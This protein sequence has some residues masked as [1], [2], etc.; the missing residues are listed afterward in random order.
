MDKMSLTRFREIKEKMAILPKLASGEISED[1]VTEEMAEEYDAL[2]DELHNSD[3]SDIPVSEYEGFFDPGVDFEGTGA[4][5]DFSII[6]E[7]YRDS[8]P[9]RVKGCNISNFDFDRIPY[10]ED[11]FEEEF[12]MA[13]R[14]RFWGLDGQDIPKEVR[15]RYNNGRLT[16]SDIITYDLEDIPE[17]KIDYQARK[18]LK[19][20][21]RD[22]LKQA[23]LELIDV[24]SYHLD[25][26]INSNGIATLDEYNS[27]LKECLI[28]LLDGYTREELYDRLSSNSTVRELIPEYIIDFPEDKQELKESF[29]DNSIHMND[30]RA[31]LELFRGKKFVNRL[32]NYSYRTRDLDITEEKIMYLF[33]NYP[34]YADE[35]LGH[36]GYFTEIASVIDI[37]KSIE[38]NT[39]SIKDQAK[40]LANNQYLADEAEALRS[41][42]TIT[43]HIEDLGEWDR[44]RYDKILQYTTPE[45]IES[46]DIPTS[47][48][49][50]SEVISVF[51]QFGF[52]RVMEFDRENDHVFSKNDYAFLKTMYEYYLHYGGNDH[53]PRTNI[54][55]IQYAE[56]E[57]DYQRPYTKEEFEDM[58]A[59]VI[60]K[61]HLK[62]PEIDY[63]N[64]SDS[65][66]QRHSEMFLPEEATQDLKDK[67]YSRTL[68]VTD[69][70]D[71]EDWIEYLKETDYTYG[72][73][74]SG[75]YMN[76][77]EYG[78]YNYASLIDYLSNNVDKE[79]GLRFLQENGEYIRFI[80]GYIQLNDR[81][82]TDI[83]RIELGYDFSADEVKEQLEKNIVDEVFKNA[84]NNYTYEQ[85]LMY[86]QELVKYDPKITNAMRFGVSELTLENPT[87]EDF[88][89]YI[90][91]KIVAGMTLGVIKYGPDDM[92]NE[93]KEK[94]PEFFISDDA[95]EILK[96]KFYTGYQ[97]V[98]PSI[99]E[100]ERISVKNKFGISDLTNPEFI[101]F[102]ETKKIPN[103]SRELVLLQ[104][105]FS[106]NQLIR[107]VSIDSEAFLLYAQN[108]ETVAKLRNAF[109][110]YPSNFAREEV[111]SR[112]K[113]SELEF[114]DRIKT[115]SEF[116][117]AYQ[118]AILEYEK[119]IVSMPG[120]VLC[121]PEELTRTDL[122]NYRNLLDNNDLKNSPDFRRDVY[123]QI[124]GNMYGLM[125]FDESKRL[126]ESPELSPESLDEVYQIDGRI[127]DLYEKKFELTG[128]IKTLTT[129]LNGMPSLLPG[130]E[131]VSSRN[132]LNLFKTI[133]QKISEGY[134]G[135][136]Q[137]LLANALQ[138]N[139]FEVNSQAMQ[140]LTG[141]VISMH[142]EMKLENL[143]EFTSTVIESRIQENAKT[144]KRIKEIY[145][146][147]LKYS[148]NKSE[149]V[150]STLVREYLENEFKRVKENGMP[151]YSP[152]V[153]KHL[154]DLV[155]FSK[156]LSQNPEIDAIANKTIV[157]SLNE[158]SK[159]IGKGWIRKV[160][161]AAN[162][163]NKMT[164]EQA[165][166]LD[167]S[168]YGEDSPYETE[169]KETVGLKVLTDEERQSIYEILKQANY[170]K[171]LTFNKAEMMFSGIVAPFSEEFKKFF[172]ANKDEF[173]EN[174]EYYTQFAK[175]HNKF[176]RII[177]EPSIKT[178]Y[179]EGLFTIQDLLNEINTVRYD[180]VRPGEYELDYVGRKG[181]L[182][183]EQF[184][185]AQRL[186]KDVL[187][188][189]FSTVP[190]EEHSTGKYRGRIVR[191]DDPLHL[192]I[193][194][195][196]DCCQT[197][198]ENDPGESSMIHSATE[199]NG[200]LFVVEE[201]DDYGNPTRIVAQSWTWRNGNRVTFDNVEIP[202]SVHS[203]LQQIGGFDEIMEAY[204]GAAQKIIETDKKALEKLLK[205]G[206][207]TREQYEQ[208]VV[209]DVAMG[210]GCDDLISQLSKDTRA[211]YPSVKSVT[212][213][214]LGKTYV[215]ARSRGLYTDASNTIL[216]A[217]ND[218]FSQDDH[219]VFTGEAK[220]L[221]IKYSKTR[222]IFR[223]RGNDIDIDK[224]AKIKSMV[225]R[226]GQ[227]SIFSDD[228]KYV[229]DIIDEV[230]PYSYYGERDTID[231]DG[232][233]LSMSEM[234]DWFVFVEETDS[235]VTFHDSGI[236]TLLIETATEKEKMDKKMAIAEY[237]K[238]ALSYFSEAAQSGKSIFINPEREGKILPIESLK[239]A[240]EIEVSEDGKVTI[241]DSE[242][243]R[244]RIDVLSQ[245]IETDRRQRI[246][247]SVDSKTDE[248]R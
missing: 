23:D 207:I 164:Y 20:I 217:H 119:D 148:L 243:L 9:I 150:D 170:A 247:D 168:I 116:Q 39:A 127:K 167:K 52:E 26:R 76:L 81:T 43:D 163:P 125:G 107:L 8:R 181:G 222:D 122:R 152:H 136:I 248:E 105:K 16:L 147:A 144:R 159:K 53:N 188:R 50:N 180:N 234:G 41:I 4:N 143:R 211:K 7:E 67:F 182:D 68:L 192:A 102:I 5:L 93:F 178:R 28:E 31:N 71:H 85:K 213:L 11:S 54:Y 158:E 77:K 69:L 33:D 48:L 189:E 118:K 79:Q 134:N 199:H 154:E 146:D 27:V 225:Q 184:T 208:F 185:I 86:I 90:D 215:G 63:R 10:D 113:I 214:E 187:K 201:L 172:L 156:E 242:K 87:R 42:L 84:G 45:V 89:R 22:I 13:N 220:E 228:V 218:D 38:E 129:L 227:N 61:G 160:L 56:N 202:H 246:V 239:E 126:L 94:H 6:N 194:E 177:H 155:D 237:T 140:D 62:K 18:V 110:L 209:K 121:G 120:L 59:R 60:R 130:T 138:E 206:K 145:R 196:T 162:Y 66:K 108:E 229:Q 224:I 73:Q 205:E 57:R 141:R 197:I 74:I 200:S 21:P 195:I 203:Q 169:T 29:L 15:N 82:R 204:F 236:D 91:G 191:I 165:V 99:P 223:R 151:F 111:C 142:T 95:P 72:F 98:D 114:F 1:D 3:L 216:V 34:E 30:I 244:K 226:T 36:T 231:P 19:K 25:T 245:I 171:V 131:K 70:A 183:Q 133:N 64:F 193:G 212:P 157:D 65:F 128:N 104:Q 40:M 190:P 47:I 101:P 92:P 103:A 173:I 35:L 166:A 219:R 51:H 175:M 112:F 58:M 198:G 12:V 88:A 233:R 115:D 137:S 97:S 96:V 238:E 139:G 46:Y 100:N 153:T 109:D 179:D 186:Y 75:T 241:L 135:D 161:Q 2:F 78:P 232:Y 44:E 17:S 149:K 123:E 230:H 174:P 49:T 210:T 124:I 14:E 235:K 32:R 24:L 55:T 176:D 117:E 240:G 106:I 37:N 132:T 80:D 221:G 83:G